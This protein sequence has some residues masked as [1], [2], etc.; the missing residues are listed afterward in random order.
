M[1]FSRA[2]LGA[3]GSRSLDKSGWGKHPT[4]WT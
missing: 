4:L 1:I 3:I 2:E